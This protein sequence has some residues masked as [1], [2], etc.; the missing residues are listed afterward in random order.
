MDSELGADGLLGKSRSPRNTVSAN[1]CAPRGAPTR[2]AICPPFEHCHR[3]RP[4][5]TVFH[6]S[7]YIERRLRLGF[8]LATTTPLQCPRR[9][10]ADGRMNS[11]SASQREDGQSSCCEASLVYT[12]WSRHQTLIEVLVAA[13]GSFPNVEPLSRRF[14]KR[15]SRCA[16]R[17]LSDF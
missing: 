16:P 7:C 11:R 4:P 13:S 17:R 5:P 8:P 3:H 2:R 14:S 12:L 6:V 9:L 10:A 15:S 1:A